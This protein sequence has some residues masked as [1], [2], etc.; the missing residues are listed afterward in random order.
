MLPEWGD[1]REIDLPPKKN[2]P[3]TEDP[4]A[5]PGFNSAT[6]VLVSADGTTNQARYFMPARSSSRKTS[7]LV[8]LAGDDQIAAT[9]MESLVTSLLRGGSAALVIKPR[10]VKVADD[11]ISIFY[12]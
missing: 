1:T 8:V 10:I 9:N 2:E 4:K 12:T 5:G 6:V 11:P 3:R 7:R